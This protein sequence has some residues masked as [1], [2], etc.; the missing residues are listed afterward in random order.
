MPNNKPTHDVYIVIEATDTQKKP[1]WKKIGAAWTHQDGK[2]F[3]ITLDA[4]PLNGKLTMRIP[5][6]KP[7]QDNDASSV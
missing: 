1:L 4:L 3:G 6:E 2:G 7:S 5:E